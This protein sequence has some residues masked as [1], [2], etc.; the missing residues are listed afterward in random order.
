MIKMQTRFENLK[1]QADK[2]RTFDISA[3]ETKVEY[4]VGTD[5]DVEK[6]HTWHD[7][8]VHVIKVGDKIY[9]FKVDKYGN[10]I[11]SSSVIKNTSMSDAY[12]D[13]V[14]QW[15]EIKRVNVY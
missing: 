13:I 15:E 8:T 6:T 3:R 5:K 11:S 14:T 4:H 9:E 12:T 1:A 2:H 7:Q 10:A